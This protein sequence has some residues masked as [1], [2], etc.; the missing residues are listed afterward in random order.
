ALR[1]QLQRLV[2]FA[3]A[4]ERDELCAFVT[5]EMIDQ[6][7]VRERVEPG[8]KFGFHLVASARLNQVEPDVLQQLLCRGTAAA[9]PEQIT[10][11]AAA[12][13]RVEQI[14]G[15]GIAAAI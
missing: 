2:L 11:H 5:A 10:E 8:R 6:P 13:A 7:V 9:L 12:M 15:G 3:F 1:R 14:E 4:V